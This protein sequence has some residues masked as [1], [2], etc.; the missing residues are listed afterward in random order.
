MRIGLTG[1]I[2]SGKSLVATMFQQRGAAI[3]DTDAIAH[4]L[5]MPGG[6]A[7]PAIV[8]AFG[9]DAL[10]AR[11]AMDRAKMRTRVFSDD[12]ARRDLEAILHPR[13]RAETDR[14][15]DAALT[16]GAPYALIAVPL[17]VESG[18][19]AQRVDR[20]LVVDCPVAVQ[21]HR[22]TTTRGLPQ[23]QVQAIVERQA[24]RASRLAVA[25]DIIVND[26]LSPVA[27]TPRIE[28]LHALYLGLSQTQGTAGAA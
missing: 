28:R 16:A 8:H 9:E 27:L 15:I 25:D 10:D 3:V 2:G 5:T 17:L 11:G 7:I 22:V 19:W 13:I 4:A 14:Q 12:S 24:S 1:G 6:A 26:R 21:L 23:A 18:G 20:I